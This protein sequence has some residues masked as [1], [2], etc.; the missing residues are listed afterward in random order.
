MNAEKFKDI[1]VNKLKM[2]QGQ[3]ADALGLHRITLWRLERGDSPVTRVLELA[4][5]SV[6]PKA[7]G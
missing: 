6:K 7:K 1:R 5:R 4:M 2:S 3:L